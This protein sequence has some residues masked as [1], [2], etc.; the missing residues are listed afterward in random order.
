MQIKIAKA[1]GLNTD[2]KAA[3]TFSSSQD[4]VS[5]LAVLQL[6]CD[7]AFTRGRQLLNLLSETFF[8][9]EGGVGQ[10]LQEAFGEGQKSLSDTENFELLLGVV[11]GKA[12]YLMSTG[13]IGAILKRES[14]L[15][16]LLESHESQL[17]S[18]FLNE[19]DRVFLATKSLMELLG[20]DSVA[21]NLPL[22]IWEEQTSSKLGVEG[23]DQQGFAGLLLSLESDAIEDETLKSLGEK[24]D[25]NAADSTK[26]PKSKL[27]WPRIGV[28]LRGVF[29]LFPKSGRG[30]LFLALL[31][32]LVVCSGVFY[33]YFSNKNKEKEDT[34]NAYFQSAKDDYSVA[35]SLQTLNTTEAQVKLNS[36]KSNLDKALALKPDQAEAKEFKNKINQE[37]S[38]ILQQHSSEFS[39]FLD[40][41]LIKEGLVASKMSLSTGKILILD[42]L[43]KTLAILDVAKKSHKILAGKDKLGGVESVSL[44]GGSAFIYSKDKGVLR[45]DINNNQLIVVAKVDDEWGSIS[46]L[47][48]FGGNVY[49]LD[50]LKNQIWKYLPSSSGYSDKR[51]YLEKGIKADFAG[52]RLMQIESSIYI[53]K[54]GSEILRF[55]KGVKDQFSIN[56]LDKD[57]KDPKSIFTGS[58][59]DNLYILDSGNSR[60]VVVDKIGVYKAQYQ[61]DK[62]GASSDLVVDEKGKKVYLLESNKIYTMD[63][64]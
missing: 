15:S 7:D 56:G 2:L 34:F 27:S 4:D 36:A 19:G 30:R 52:A 53:L 39:L 10:K 3:L 37:E 43:S 42:D 6:S 33:Q 26:S 62:F 22:E 24:G 11:S 40:L 32:I 55:T 45:V 1:L 31:L 58:E 5:F 60:L 9:S 44:N 25:I 17:I 14:N 29:G 64:R 12:L 41:S 50:S 38:Q 51:E 46:D 54:S 35:L 8:A 57:L 47:Y 59:V 61:G 28:S 20:N 23:L 21:L 48:G 49:L 18:G 63:L 13:E 16:S